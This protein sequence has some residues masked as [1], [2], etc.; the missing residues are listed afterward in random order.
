MIY[1][2]FATLIWSFSFG[3]IKENLELLDPILVSTI[4]MFLAMIIFIPLMKIREISLN[5]KL[6]LMLVGAVQFGLMYIFYIYSFRY[7]QSYE[8]AVSTIF[9][10]VYISLLYAFE[11]NKF[12][13]KIVYLSFF[14]VIGAGIVIYSGISSPLFFKGFIIIQISNLCFAWGQLKYRKIMRS[15]TKIKD[16]EIFGYLYAGAF[17]LTLLSYI[18]LGKKIG[19]VINH[20]QVLTLIYLGIIA[21]G[22]A[23]FFWNKGVRTAKIETL[24]IFNN[25]KIPL[26][27]TVSL[28][29][30]NEK[31]NL[32]QLLAGG[33]IL[34][35]LIVFA[36]KIPKRDV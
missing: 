9:T 14:S 12:E 23:F 35:A 20:S 27:V 32:I 24:S 31:G 11:T 16:S 5:I 36:E 29:F 6:K 17:L 18:L 2:F 13:K 22:V 10:P 15:I 8:V 1:L 26:A 28:L 33:I 3:L 34:F 7:L 4:R 21:S 30:F 19:I 25:T